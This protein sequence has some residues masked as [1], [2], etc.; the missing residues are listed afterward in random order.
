MTKDYDLYNILGV[1][2]NASVDEIKNSYRRLARK[3]H[4]D[5][6]P[7]KD[8]EER[9][10]LINIAYDV[11][12]DPVKRQQYDFMRRYGIDSGANVYSTNYGETIEFKSLS[13]FFE[14]LSKLEDEELNQLLDSLFGQLFLNFIKG[15]WE[16]GDRFRKRFRETIQNTVRNFEKTVRTFFDL[17]GGR[18][19]S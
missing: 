17:F 3:Y 18:R 9:I 16:M 7:S 5:I 15:L 6:N 8:A 11:L 12:S 10:K 14:F 4:P 1:N 19:T 13:E 2:T